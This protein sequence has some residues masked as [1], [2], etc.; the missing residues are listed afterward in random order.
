MRVFPTAG[1]LASRAGVCPGSNESAGR[2]KSTRI[3]PGNRFIK[4]ATGIAAMAAV[5]S[6]DTFF[7]AKYRRIASRR[8][9][10]KALVAVEYAM[11]VAAWNMLTD[12]AFYRELGANYYTARKPA[13]TKAHAVGQLETLGYRVTL[14][15]LADTA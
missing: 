4:G 2:V 6:K 1:D 13:K 7:S 12:C 3:L 11:V 8:G 15:P 5:R 14:E 10:T 9:P